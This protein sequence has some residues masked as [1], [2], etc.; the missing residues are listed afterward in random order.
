MKSKIFFIC[1]VILT[2]S[3]A[4]VSAQLMQ[5][6]SGRPIMSRKYVDVEGS[7]YLFEEWLK[8]EVIANGTVYKDIDLKFDQVEG[9][10]F[11][12][13]TKGDELDFIHSIESFRI[14]TPVGLRSFSRFPQVRDDHDNP[15]FEALSEGDKATLLKKSSK[16][17]RETKAFNSATTTRSFYD[18]VNYYVLKKDGSFVKVR[19]DKKSLIGA[20]SDKSAELEAYVKE[21]KVNFKEDNQMGALV[22]YYNTL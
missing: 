9:R 18:V 4:S 14:N 10:V 12:K 8:G 16:S 5:D 15:F 3:G 21:H 1:C 17:I 7:P 19:K 13:N 6:V 11:F 20:L 2:L 22:S